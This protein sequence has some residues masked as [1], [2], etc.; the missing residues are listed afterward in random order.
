MS[1]SQRRD[2]RSAEEQ[3]Q[4]PEWSAFHLEIPT[5]ERPVA[6]SGAADSGS[7][8]IAVK[9]EGTLYL[10]SLRIRSDDIPRKVKDIVMSN[11]TTSAYIWAD[12]RA[13][14]GQC[15]DVLDSLRAAGI[16]RAGLITERQGQGGSQKADNSVP[17]G[18]EVLLPEPPPPQGKEY[19]LFNK[20]RLVTPPVIPKRIP[21]EC[22][23]GDTIDCTVILVIDKGKDLLLN[24]DQ[25]PPD[26]LGELLTEVFRKRAEKVIFVKADP[27][28]EYGTVAKAI[29]IAYGAGIDKIGLIIQ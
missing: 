23:A 1:C 10:G 17:M 19:T 16:G 26:R 15:M 25:I 11:P 9:R 24:T 7:L 29:D 14:Y 3:A 2:N 13:R 27:D 12:K 18:E 5:T 20:G 22:K 8:R 21:I 4:P 6:I 28:L